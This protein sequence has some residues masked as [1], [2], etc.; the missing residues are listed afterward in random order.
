MTCLVCG[1]A[2]PIFNTVLAKQSMEQ[3]ELVRDV[4]F[5]FHYDD[6]THRE[7]RASRKTV[8][9]AENIAFPRSNNESQPIST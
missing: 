3:G 1:R 2:V 9:E 8:T 5:S 4:V 6:K 7:C